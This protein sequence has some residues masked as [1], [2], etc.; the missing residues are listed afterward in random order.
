MCRQDVHFPLVVD[1][2]GMAQGSV[3]EGMFLERTETLAS[4]WLRLSGGCSQ[5]SDSDPSLGLPR[6]LCSLLL[7]TTQISPSA[8]LP[9]CCSSL[10]EASGQLICLQEAFL[11]LPLLPH[12]STAWAG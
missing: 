10:R 9:A 2:Q 7:L 12:F 11:A 8:A 5:P 1:L 4:D 3:G 6:L